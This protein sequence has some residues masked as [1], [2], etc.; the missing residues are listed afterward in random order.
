M[1]IGLAFFYH[2]RDN[3]LGGFAH[4]HDQPPKARSARDT[5]RLKH[6]N[7][8]T[9]APHDPNDDSSK[10]TSGMWRI[11]ATGIAFVEGELRVPRVKHV[12]DDVV[13]SESDETTSMAQ[14][15]GDGFDYLEV[16]RGVLPW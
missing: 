15:L 10:R 6:W 13:I 3:E 9:A 1:A 2:Q 11:T 14:A 8:I 12:F 16:L 4:M 5:S 7:M